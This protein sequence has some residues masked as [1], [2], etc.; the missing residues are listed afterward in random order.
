MYPGKSFGKGVGEREGERET[1][2]QNGFPLPLV[3]KT[4][5]R[6]RR[7][8][9]FLLSCGVFFWYA[10]GG[11]RRRREAVVPRHPVC[12]PDKSFRKGEGEREGERETLLK[13][14]LPLPLAKNP[15]PTINEV[16]E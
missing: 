7:A 5:R 12:D 15:L 13:K 1:V 6:N 11:R 3:K 2:F 9:I 4:L 8:G 14:G 16:P 10:A